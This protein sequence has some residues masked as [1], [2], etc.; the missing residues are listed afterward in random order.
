MTTL[1]ESRQFTGQEVIGASRDQF[2]VDVK[3]ETVILGLKDGLY[4]GLD[5]IGT[6]VWNLIQQPR[7]LEEIRSI[8]LEEYDVEPDVCTEDLTSLISE[9]A[10]KGL[11][12][13]RR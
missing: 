9:L 12:E 5:P 13:I 6:R 8:L 10:Q 4:Y 7:T 2:S 11:V 1:G 3:D